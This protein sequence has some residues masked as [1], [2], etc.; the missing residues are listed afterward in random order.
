PLTQLIELDSESSE[1]RILAEITAS[2]PADVI[3]S[4]DGEYAAFL[5]PGDEI[6]QQ[7]VVVIDIVGGSTDVIQEDV[8]VGTGLIAWHDQL[9]LNL[10]DG[11]L[12]GWI[13]DAGMQQLAEGILGITWNMDK[14]P[15][16][17]DANHIF[18]LR[19]GEQIPIKTDISGFDV[20]LARGL[21][22][23]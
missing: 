21:R 19:D 12:L 7:H 23:E 6:G 9:L 13:P 11:V 15:V 16:L 8:P 10:A 1:S 20:V 3:F 22:L 2:Y 14:N 17:V 4:S 18:L 5:A